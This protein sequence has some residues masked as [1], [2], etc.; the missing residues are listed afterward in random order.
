MSLLFNEPATEWLRW[1]G[2]LNKDPTIRLDGDR[3]PKIC[4]WAYKISQKL[5]N[6]FD[7]KKLN[8]NAVISG[9]VIAK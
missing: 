6:S 9:K 2:V 7:G 5:P 4:L 8:L 3:S 1:P